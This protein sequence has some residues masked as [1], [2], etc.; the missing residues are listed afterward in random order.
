MKAFSLEYPPKKPLFTYLVLIESFHVYIL[1]P[2]IRHVFFLCCTW[3]RITTRQMNFFCLLQSS[4][5][6]HHIIK[7]TKAKYVNDKI[8]VKT[9]LMNPMIL[10]FSLFYIQFFK[11]KNKMKT[12]WHFHNKKWK[13]KM[14]TL[15]IFVNQT[16]SK[17]ILWSQN[18]FYSLQNWF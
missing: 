16:H 5:L 17:K 13:L 1:S 8:V 7:H 10:L 3:F 4:T 9:V 2:Y 12:I 18:Q 11:N 6:S 15:N 14:K